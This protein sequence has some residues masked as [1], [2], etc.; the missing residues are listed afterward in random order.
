MGDYQ[1]YLAEFATGG[2][3]KSLEAYKVTSDVTIIELPPIRLGLTELLCD[4]QWRAYHLV[5]QTSNDDI[6]ELD[7]LSKKRYEDSTFTTLLLE[8]NLTLWTSDMQD[9]GMCSIDS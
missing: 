3:A 7:T 9:S 2:K 5:K 8:D 4:L 1:Q 6:M